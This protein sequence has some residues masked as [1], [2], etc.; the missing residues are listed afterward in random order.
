MLFEF[1]VNK[2][3]PLKGQG[4]GSG[5]GFIFAKRPSNCKIEKNNIIAKVISGFE[6]KMT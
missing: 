4:K 6:R 1:S 2:F 5:N 3:I